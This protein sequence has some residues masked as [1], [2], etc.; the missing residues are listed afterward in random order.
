MQDHDS[1]PALDRRTLLAGL[2][3]LTATATLSGCGGDESTTSAAGTVLGSTGEV[4]VGEGKV[5][6]QQ[7]VVVTQPVQ[8]TFHAFSAICTHQGCT[9]GDVA[10]GTIN[11]PCHGSKFDVTDGSVVRGPAQQPLAQMGVAVEA[12]SLTLR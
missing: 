8:G 10:G 1:R 12:G 6:A 7:R 5:Y 9:V 4:P 11:C 2:S 3:A